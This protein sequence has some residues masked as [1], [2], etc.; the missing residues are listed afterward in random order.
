MCNFLSSSYIPSFCNYRHF[1]NRR[2]VRFE[3]CARRCGRN[4]KFQNCCSQDF[5]DSA[6]SSRRSRAV[7]SGR[8]CS[9][10]M[11]VKRTRTTGSY[12]SARRNRIRI[13]KRSAALPVRQ[14]APRRNAQQ[15]RAILDQIAAVFEP[16][17]R[18]TGISVRSFEEVNYNRV[19][20][21]RN[22]NA[23][24]V[25]ELVLRRSVMAYPPIPTSVESRRGMDRFQQISS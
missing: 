14:N 2:M 25:I 3:S 22:W 8:G 21:G 16:L 17:M 7:F 5:C 23:G 1:R 20:A 12:S 9:G 10:S 6:L 24:E 13:M 4:W 11:R 15:A 18:E 19:F